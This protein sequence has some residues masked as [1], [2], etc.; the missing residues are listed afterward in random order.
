MTG[1]L[2]SAGAGK[3]FFYLHHRVQ[4]GFGTHPTSYPMVTGGFFPPG[5]KAAG[6]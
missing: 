3:E 1:V 2:F 6:P 4:T 5:C